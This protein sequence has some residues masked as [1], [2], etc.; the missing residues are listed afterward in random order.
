[1][2]ERIRIRAGGDLAN[3]DVVRAAATLAVPA[4]VIHDADDT[5]VPYAQGRDI[6]A[7]WPGARFATVRG[8]GHRGTLTDPAVLAAVA[9]FAAGHPIEQEAFAT[10]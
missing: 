4:L 6:A 1:M 8:L 9:S 10:A 5:T 2:R 3:I 7:A